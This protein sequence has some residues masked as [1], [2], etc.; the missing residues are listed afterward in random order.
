MSAK[1]E[2]SLDFAWL[3]KYVNEA[4]YG[5]SAEDNSQTNDVNGQIDD[6]PVRIRLFLDISAC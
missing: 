4:T 3:S 6:L 1:K 5:R 2:N